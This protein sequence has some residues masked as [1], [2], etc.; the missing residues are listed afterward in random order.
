MEKKLAV[1]E[2]GFCHRRL[3]KW[4]MGAR[5]LDGWMDGLRGEGGR[6]NPGFLTIRGNGTTAVSEEVSELRDGRTSN[7]SSFRKRRGSNQQLVG[8]RSLRHSAAAATA[9]L[10][11]FLLLIFNGD[12]GHMG[13]L[14]AAWKG[15]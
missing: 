12:Q 1:L 6:S 11:F 7:A 3:G 10:F 2:L 13:N 15:R 5:W 8:V 9:P 4:R 14:Q